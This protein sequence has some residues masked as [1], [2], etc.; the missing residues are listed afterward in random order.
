VVAGSSFLVALVF[1]TILLVIPPVIVSAAVDA[2]TPAA[3]TPPRDLP[4]L[5]DS[6]S[7]ALRSL[8]RR[9]NGRRSSVTAWLGSSRGDHRHRSRERDR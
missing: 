2:A 8:P 7:D 9:P 1:T 3:D 4:V 5:L 6:T